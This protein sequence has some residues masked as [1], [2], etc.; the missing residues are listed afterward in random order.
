MKPQKYDYDNHYIALNPHNMNI[1]VHC[2]TLENVSNLIK[3]M[4]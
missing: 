3:V 1:T 2:L 4:Q